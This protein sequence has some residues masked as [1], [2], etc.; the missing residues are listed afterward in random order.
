[1]FRNERVQSKVTP[2]KVG[3]GLKQREELNNG[4]GTKDEFGGI[5]LEDRDLT[6]A[7][8]ERKAPVLRQTLQSNQSS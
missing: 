2:R 7:W 5:H 4:G 8:I 1:M 3:V 6:F